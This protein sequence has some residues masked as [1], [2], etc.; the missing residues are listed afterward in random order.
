MFIKRFYRIMTNLGVARQSQDQLKS[1]RSS[2]NYGAV[3][4]SYEDR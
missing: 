2:P 3:Q 4:V 1:R